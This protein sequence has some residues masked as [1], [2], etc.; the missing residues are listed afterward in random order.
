M[1]IPEHRYTADPLYGNGTSPVL[2]DYLLP[3]GAAE[4]SPEVNPDLYF[5]NPNYTS[6]DQ[7]LSF[8][9]IEK[10]N[11]AGT[12]WYHSVVKNAPIQSY[13]LSVSGGT[14]NAHYMMSANYFDQQGVVTGTY[15][16]RGSIRA[17]T[18][19]NVSKNIVYRGKPGVYDYR[20]SKNNQLAV[21]WSDCLYLSFTA[22][23]SRCMT[24][25]EITAVVLAEP[26]WVIHQIR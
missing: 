9:H 10:A 21:L 25:R 18:S 13:N 8:Y 16:K 1:P 7:Y 5:I 12:D 11:K 20:K 22:H 4:G 2:P 23:H 15:L 6:V 17:N 3:A 19:F 24:S 26:G 14:E